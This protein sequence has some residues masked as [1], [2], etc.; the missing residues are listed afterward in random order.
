MVCVVGY[1]KKCP[2]NSEWAR[3]LFH[4]Y[5]LYTDDDSA[6]IEIIV[7]LKFS[8]CFAFSS[9]SSSENVMT[10]TTNT[11]TTT[12]LC[13]HCTEDTGCAYTFNFWTQSNKHAHTH[14]HIQSTLK[15]IRFCMNRFQ[16]SF[17]MYVYIWNLSACVYVHI[18]CGFFFT[19]FS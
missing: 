12:T 1:N 2:I 3:R 9:S 11:S 4:A 14:T 7:Q 16:Y 18:C 17:P 5:V 10:T 19:S 15:F 6:H 8:Y 13:V